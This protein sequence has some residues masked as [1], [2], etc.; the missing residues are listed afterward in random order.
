MAETKARTAGELVDAY[1]EDARYGNHGESERRAIGEFVLDAMDGNDED[2][3]V[4]QAASLA[5]S[6]AEF[7]REMAADL[8]RLKPEKKPRVK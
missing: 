2:D 7:A 8:R 1:L 5:D 6:L 4:E 3:P